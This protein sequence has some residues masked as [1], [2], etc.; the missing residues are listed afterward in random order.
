V[1]TE[2]IPGDGIRGSRYRVAG[3]EQPFIRMN[4]NSYLGLV[5]D[6]RLIAAAEAATQ[7]FGV[8]PGAR[9]VLSA[10]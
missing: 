5:A 2:R 7:R 10:E 3:Y 9:Y 6:P 4:S 8:G 1:I